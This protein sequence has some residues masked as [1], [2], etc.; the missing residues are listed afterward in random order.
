MAIVLLETLA[1]RTVA[2]DIFR[3]QGDYACGFLENFHDGLG[4]YNY[5][6]NIK[7]L[8]RPQQAMQ[9]FFLCLPRGVYFPVRLD[10]S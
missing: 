9:T 6:G 5:Q 8:A 3:A 1:A 7:M 10:C 2:G 4:F